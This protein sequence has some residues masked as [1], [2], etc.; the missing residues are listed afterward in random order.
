M[1]QQRNGDARQRQPLRL[2]SFILGRQHF[3]ILSFEPAAAEEES[4][5]AESFS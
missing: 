4:C 1:K 5:R 2:K 3:P